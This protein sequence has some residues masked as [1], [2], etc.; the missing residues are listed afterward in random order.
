MQSKVFEALLCREQTP[1]A[2]VPVTRTTD[3]PV[4]DLMSPA[5]AGLHRALAVVASFDQ[6]PLCVHKQ[7]YKSKWPY[8]NRFLIRIANP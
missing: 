6:Q 3:F 4:K 1:S 2:M 8:S 5:V 7:M